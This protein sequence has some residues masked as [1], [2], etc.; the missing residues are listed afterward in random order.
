MNPT[1][2]PIWWLLRRWRTRPIS[3][4]RS[5][6]RRTTESN[7]IVLDGGQRLVHQDDYQD[8]RRH[9]RRVSALGG[10][11]VGARPGL[12]R[13]H[14]P[15]GRDRSFRDMVSAAGAGFQSVHCFGVL[16]GIRRHPFERSRTFVRVSVESFANSGAPA[17]VHGIRA[18]VYVQ[19]TWEFTVLGRTGSVHSA[20]SRDQTLLADQ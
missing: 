7:R 4:N 12:F 20:A 10:I 19:S 1:A 9:P 3:S 11:A 18:A 15:A 5:S 17:S 16:G 8:D 6:Q 14:K 2:T 13:P